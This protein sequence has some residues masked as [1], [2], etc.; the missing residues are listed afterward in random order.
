MVVQTCTPPNLNTHK[1][2]NCI[3]SDG[4]IDFFAFNNK[5]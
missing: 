1:D 2:P 4:D 5:S 3:A